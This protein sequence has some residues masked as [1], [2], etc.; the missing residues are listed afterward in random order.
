MRSR[1]LLNAVVLLFAMT[2][3]AFSEPK[4]V[5][6]LHS[7]GR[8]FAPWNQYARTIREELVRQSSGP[9]DF[10]E[11][12]LATARFADDDEGP[13]VDYLRA[14][15]V[16]RKLDLIVTIA[17]P[18]ASF[19]QRHRQQ[20]F[21]STPLLIT[22]LEQRRVA[23]TTLTAN[24]TVVATKIDFARAVENILQVLPE[25]GNIAVVIGDSPIERYWVEQMRDEVRPFNDRIAFTWLNDLS[26]DQMLKHVATLPP[27]SAI[28]FGILSVDAAGVPHE[29][30]S[31]LRKFHAAA[32]APIFSYGDAFF[33]DGIVGGPLGNIENVGRKAA[34]VAVRILGGEVPGNI[35]TAPM[36]F[37][38][39]KFDWRELQRWNISESRLPAGSQVYFR[40][41]GMWEQYR[42]QVTTGA[43]ALLL[44]AAIICWLLVERRRRHF[45][46]AEATSRRR[47]VIHLNRVTT[48]SVLSS[49][50]AHELNQPLGAILSNTEAAQIMNEDQP[51]RRWPD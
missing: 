11:A 42:L 43:A 20:L 12:S 49:S 10:F 39:P 13:F 2:G 50:I 7:F 31:A 46:Q 38:T 4:R 15:F 28:F 23:L 21:P 29:E 35:K 26:V 9:I 8:D 51:N 5:L 16:K 37:A 19:F 41:P 45:A 3:A 17:A 40:V 44:Q 1:I 34:S 18:A 14:L 27:R 24:D 36:G 47:E 25:T 22:A 30:A 6:L 33:G 48:A 32:N